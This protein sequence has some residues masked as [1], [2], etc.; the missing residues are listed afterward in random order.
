VDLGVSGSIKTGAPGG[1]VAAAW[2]LGVFV[3]N[4]VSL[5][6]TGYITIEIVDPGTGI[7][8]TYNLALAI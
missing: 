4:T 8:T 1:S 7:G 3:T 5:D 6:T 2:K